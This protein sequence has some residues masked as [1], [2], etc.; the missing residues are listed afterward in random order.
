ME[1]QVDLAKVGHVYRKAALVD[2]KIHLA[3]PKVVPERV[4][5]VGPTQIPVDPKVV[6]ERVVLIG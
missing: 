6:P 4:V 1:S 5:L 2:Y 3:G